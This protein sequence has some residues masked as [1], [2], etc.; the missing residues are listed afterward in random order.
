MVEEGLRNQISTVR[1]A[2]KGKGGIDIEYMRVIEQLGVFS[3]LGYSQRKGT[4][5]TGERL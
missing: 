2:G 5:L 4:R 1:V 3:Q